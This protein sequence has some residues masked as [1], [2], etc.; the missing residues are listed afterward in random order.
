MARWRDGGKGRMG[1][2][3]CIFWPAVC[4]PGPRPPAGPIMRMTDP[5]A[6]DSIYLVCVKFCGLAR[7]GP[8]SLTV[9]R[10]HL[11][12]GLALFP[13]SLALKRPK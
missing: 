7:A 13:V 11:D 6:C 9:S 2:G 5:G 1:Q 12:L 10:Q 3:S 8:V 4:L